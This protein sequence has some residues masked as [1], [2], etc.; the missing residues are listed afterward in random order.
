MPFQGN[1]RAGAGD[2]AFLQ[3]LFNRI[4]QRQKNE[5]QQQLDQI[6]LAEKVAKQRREE[7]KDAFDR[8]LKTAEFMEKRKT[9]IESL[10]DRTE[11]ASEDARSR[12]DENDA[13]IAQQQAQGVF[14]LPA[15][16]EGPRF[17]PQM[18]SEIETPQIVGQAFAPIQRDIGRLGQTQAE[19]FGEDP[20]EASMNIAE[21]VDTQAATDR[22]LRRR[23]Q[24]EERQKKELEEEFQIRKEAREAEQAAANEGS[25]DLGKIAKR[26]AETKKDLEFLP[27]LVKDRRVIEKLD[28]SEPTH[29]IE[30][31]NR[32]QRRIDDATVREGDVALLR[33]AGSSVTEE[34]LAKAKGVYD[35]TGKFP[36]EF[37][38]TLKTNLE[39]IMDEEERLVTE[40]DENRRAFG[41]SVGWNDRQMAASNP[42]P[43]LIE[44]VRE[45]RDAR[46]KEQMQQ[47]DF[48][49]SPVTDQEF[50]TVATYLSLGTNRSIDE[51]PNEEVMDGIAK[52][53][54]AQAGG[55]PQ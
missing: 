50:N 35:K 4:D 47:E 52:L 27:N 16:V 40:I 18:A 10:T 30:L 26:R 44:K 46:I 55:A 51:I 12:I 24:R 39:R 22:L 45:R 3:F 19:A 9:A 28:P 37:G 5:R 53:R 13:R 23:K 41:D 32:Y 1:P 29:V 14:D 43:S 34:L 42:Y 54:E 33:W 2:P 36:P 49:N 7:K 11:A 38:R 25:W 48:V 20:R 15:D 31:V 8:A 21:Q 6:A 17:T